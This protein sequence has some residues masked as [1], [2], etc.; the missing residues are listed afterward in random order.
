MP[1]PVSDRTTTIPSPHLGEAAT[2][3]VLN[4][5]DDL[6]SFPAASHPGVRG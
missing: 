2:A 1:I 4:G 5:R 6:T 3:I